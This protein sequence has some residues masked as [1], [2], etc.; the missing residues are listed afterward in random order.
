MQQATARAYTVQLTADMIGT[1]TA[2][3][4]TKEGW[5]LCSGS[6][7]SPL[8]T[9]SRVRRSSLSRVASESS[10]PPRSWLRAAA[11]RTDQASTLPCTGAACGCASS[12]LPGRFLR[13]AASSEVPE[14]IAL[15]TGLVC[16]TPPLK[17]ASPWFW[18]RSSS[19]A[20][21]P[22]TDQW[23]TWPCTGAACT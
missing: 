4:S 23:A 10:C 13:K 9:L 17:L 21:A 3:P 19:L 15:Y 11:P 1:T 12:E 16:C 5:F 2:K 7:V 8:L 20:A 14:V 22:R 6:I 18:P